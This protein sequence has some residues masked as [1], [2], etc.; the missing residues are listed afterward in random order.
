MTRRVRKEESDRDK[1]H[2]VVGALRILAPLAD[3]PARAVIRAELEHAAK[4]DAPPPMPE[5]P[6]VILPGRVA[7]YIADPAAFVAWAA[8][9]DTEP[10]QG[11]RLGHEVA[12]ALAHQQPVPGLTFRVRPAAALVQ[13]GAADA[14]A[15]HREAQ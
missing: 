4:S 9:Q 6:V 3:T 15:R 8:E 1:W 5:R 2:R 13:V 11:A 10:L 7:A 14:I 12:D